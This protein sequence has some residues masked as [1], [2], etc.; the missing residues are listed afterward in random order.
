MVR[1]HS[2]NEVKTELGGVVAKNSTSG[3]SKNRFEIK[4]FTAWEE[5]PIK[6]EPVEPDLHLDLDL[7]LETLT[8]SHTLGSSIS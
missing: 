8:S 7:D 3:V 6:V 1:R 4:E 2:T 5:T